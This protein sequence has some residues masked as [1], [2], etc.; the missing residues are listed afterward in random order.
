MEDIATRFVRVNLILKVGCAG[1][2]VV[3]I[4]DADAARNTLDAQICFGDL[5]FK[6][7]RL[8]ARR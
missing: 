1:K 7:N 5:N 2:R 6:S 8:F 4:I 3:L